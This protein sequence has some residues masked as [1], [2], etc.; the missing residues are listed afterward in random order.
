[1]TI[2]GP[3]HGGAL[4][5]QRARTE[6]LE[7]QLSA[8]Q[9][10]VRLLEGQLMQFEARA[11][12]A[13]ALLDLISREAARASHDVLDARASIVLADIAARACSIRSAA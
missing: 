9:A 8:T 4:T 13:E 10:G 6:F 2:I 7:A 1:M 12:S 5:A 3:T 11:T